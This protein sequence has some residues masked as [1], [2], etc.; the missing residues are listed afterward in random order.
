MNKTTL[1]IIG[2]LALI[3]IAIVVIKPPAEPK[4]VISPKEVPQKTA[5]VKK[6]GFKPAPDF[7][8]KDASGIER[9]LSD[10]KGSVVIIDF[11]ATWCPPC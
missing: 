5:S 7:S 8:L 1:F 10:F 11:W 3:I 6:T 2:A 9:K 4:K